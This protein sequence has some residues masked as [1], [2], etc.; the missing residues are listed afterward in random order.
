MSMYHFIEQ[1]VGQH[2]TRNVIAVRGD[3]TLRDLETLIADHDFNAFPVV[4]A[5]H[6]IGIVTKFDF[7]KAFAFTTQQMVPHYDELMQTPVS[8]VMTSPVVH[9]EPNAPMT[10]ALQLMLSLKARCMPVVDEAGQLVGIL[11]RQ[12]IIRALKASIEKPE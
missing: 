7:L 10:R 4:E 8:K 12:D 9:V 1:T 2:M 11:S 3:T 6:M 5:G